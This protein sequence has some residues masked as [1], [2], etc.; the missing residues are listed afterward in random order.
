MWSRQRRLEVCGREKKNEQ[1][2]KIRAREKQSKFRNNDFRKE[3]EGRKKFITNGGA[4]SGNPA[5]QTGSRWE[6]TL[7]GSIEGEE[8]IFGEKIFLREKV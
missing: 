8:K 2:E 4:V 3:K 1:K 6:E 7:C 5:P